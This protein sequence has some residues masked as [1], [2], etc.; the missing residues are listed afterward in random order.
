MPV[1]QVSICEALRPESTILL[2]PGVL[3]CAGTRVRH[4]VHCGVHPVLLP[5]RH[6]DSLLGRKG[7]SSTEETRAQEELGGTV[8][9]W[10]GAA[11][12]E[13]D[14]LS[15]RDNCGRRWRASSAS[16]LRELESIYAEVTYEY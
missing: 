13:F 2:L 5:S 7:S 8:G 6:T 1:K 16:P 11:A 10:S 12:W 4:G 15:E 14:G 9:S 3:L